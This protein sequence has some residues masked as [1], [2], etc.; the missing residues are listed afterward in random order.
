[1]N[2]NGAT[3]VQAISAGNGNHERVSCLTAALIVLDIKSAC[4]I[5]SVILSYLPKVFQTLLRIF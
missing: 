4:T 1:M 3:D 5:T 2:N